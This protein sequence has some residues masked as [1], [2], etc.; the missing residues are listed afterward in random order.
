MSRPSCVPCSIPPRCRQR[1]R[2]VP[3]SCCGM[4]SI[5]R[6]R[7]S[8][9][10]RRR[11]DRQSTCGSTGT[12]VKGSAG[13]WTDPEA[14]AVNRYRHRSDRGSSPIP[15]A[16]HRSRPG[17]RTGRAGRW[18]PTSNAPKGSTFRITTW[19]SCGG[20]KG[21]ALAVTPHLDRDVHGGPGQPVHPQHPRCHDLADRESQRPL[22]FH[23]RRL[24]VNQ[25]DRDVV[26][27]HH[28][29]IESAAAPSPPSSKQRREVKG[30]V[31][32]T[33]RVPAVDG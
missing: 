15:G 16:A 33:R 21:C 12:N 4:R 5:A 1:W 30:A 19:R 28:P 26:R 10:W 32:A 9:C 31:R 11:P 25:S 2:P 17:C 14:R 18:R 23:S 20:T 8:P 22:P 7:T 24:L 3:G 13:C 6:R 29:A 27:H